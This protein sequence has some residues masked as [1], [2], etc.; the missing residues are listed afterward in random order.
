M[1]RLRGCDRRNLVFLGPSGK[2]R[3]GEAVGP[4]LVRLAGDG[5]EAFQDQAASSRHRRN[6]GLGSRRKAPQS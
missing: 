1:K 2:V 5:R 3:H 6:A 4:A